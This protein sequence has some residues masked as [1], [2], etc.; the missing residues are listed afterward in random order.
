MYSVYVYVYVEYIAC[1]H[2]HTDP[3]CPGA[4][5][6]RVKIPFSQNEIH[7]SISHAFAA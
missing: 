6:N 3:F 4:S 2:T 5:C 7:T 1:L